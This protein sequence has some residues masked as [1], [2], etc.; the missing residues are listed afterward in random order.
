MHRYVHSQCVQL[1]R[2]ESKNAYHVSVPR[3]REN[4][5]RLEIV[6]VNDLLLVVLACLPL[7]LYF[8]LITAPAQKA[9]NFLVNVPD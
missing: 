4:I 3:R 6:M 5:Q 1:R 9:P 7:C 2:R 8:L